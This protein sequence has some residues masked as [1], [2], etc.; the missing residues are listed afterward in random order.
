[1]E[2]SRVIDITEPLVPLASALLGV[3]VCGL[4]RVITVST[5]GTI[6]LPGVLA[7]QTNAGFVTLSYTQQGLS[8]DGPTRRTEIRWATEPHLAMGAA[9]AEEWLDLAPLHDQPVFVQTLTGWFGAGSYVDTFALILSGNGR[10]LVIMTT[11]E[12]ELRI[13][14]REQA[15]R[16]AEAVAANTT[17][18]LVEA[19][20]AWEGGR[21]AGAV[22][23]GFGGGEQHADG[24]DRD[25]RG[26]GQ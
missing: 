10:E 23:P 8:C 14:D 17:M 13:A 4:W 9:D 20:L 5:D 19:R 25:G 15:R 3:T 22:E 18:R 12:L 1:V 16:R 11:D 6:P 21:P 26:V 2:Q 24:G 7:L